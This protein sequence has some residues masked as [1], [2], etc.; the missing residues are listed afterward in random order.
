MKKFSIL[1]AIIVGLMYLIPATGQSQSKPII[2]F[3]ERYD[4]DLGEIGQSSTFT[5]GYFTVMAKADDAMGLSK[6]SIQF[7]RYDLNTEKFTYYKKVPFTI[8]PSM[9]Y[10]FFESDK[11]SIEVPGVYRVYLL[12]EYDATVSASVI[13]VKSR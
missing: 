12:D 5:P 11:L 8:S 1:A 3:C 10:V 13:I 7:D 2:Y 6:V 4:N 9:K